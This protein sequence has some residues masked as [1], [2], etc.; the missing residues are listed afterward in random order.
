MTEAPENIFAEI[1]KA[2]NEIKKTQKIDLGPISRLVDQQAMLEAKLDQ[3][4]ADSLYQIVKENS[5]SLADLAEVAKMRGKDLFNV[6][7]IEIPELMKEFGLTV[8]ESTSGT[9]IQ[10][11]DGI[12]VTVKDKAAMHKFLRDTHAGDLIKDNIVITMDDEKERKEVMEV[13]ENTMCSFVQNESVNGQTLKKHVKGML[14]KGET[15]P[16]SM[17]IYEYK[18]SKIKK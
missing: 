1:T 4:N 7:Q 15:I 5:M 12:N 18:Y 14:E 2:D 6:R 8:V 3:T 16:D 13:L 9:K 11:L 10:I 17:S